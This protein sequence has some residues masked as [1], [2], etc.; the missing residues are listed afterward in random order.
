MAIRFDS[1]RFV[2]SHGKEPKGSGTWAFEREASH[3][4]AAETFFAPSWMTFA[5]ARSWAKKR[6]RAEGFQD[7]TVYVMP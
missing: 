1:S 3:G 2:R 5:E 4:M 6:V 7:A